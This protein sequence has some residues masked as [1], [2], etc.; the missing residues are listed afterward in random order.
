VKAPLLSGLFRL[1]P[2]ELGPNARRLEKIT[3]RYIRR[4]GKDVEFALSSHPKAVGE[5]ELDALAA[6]HE[7][8]CRAYDVEAITFREVVD[9]RA[10][11][12]A[13]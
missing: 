2:L 3:R 5:P 10:A 11:D 9:G 12:A 13:D 4:V 1:Y 8:L 6:Y 7:W